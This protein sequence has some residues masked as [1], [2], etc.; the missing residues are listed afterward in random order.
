VTVTLASVS[1]VPGST[2]TPPEASAFIPANGIGDG[3][4]PWT[5]D[6]TAPRSRPAAPAIACAVSF[7][8]ATA[9]ASACF[10]SAS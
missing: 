4:P 1:S 5:I 3:A 7:A 8:S 6:Y 2:G 9:F 10:A